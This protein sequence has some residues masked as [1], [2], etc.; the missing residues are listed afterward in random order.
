[1]K[2]Q[3]RPIAALSAPV[4]MA[5][6]LASCGASK[7]TQCNKLVKVANQ[8]TSLN[9]TL[10]QQKTS[11]GASTLTETS[12]KLDR[13]AQDMAALSIEDEILKG[14]QGRFIGM[15]RNTSQGLKTGA[16]ALQKKDLT[17]LK[18]AMNTLQ[19]VISQEGGLVKEVNNYCSGS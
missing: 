2:L 9:Q 4:V 3:L 15:Y 6:L 18:Q 8:A 1:M 10:S 19:G 5:V 7:V 12:N 14:F 11:K 17:S 16:I 13:L